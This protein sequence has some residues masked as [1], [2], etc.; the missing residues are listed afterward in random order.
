MPTNVDPKLKL[1]RKQLSAFIPDHDTIVQFERLIAYINTLVPEDNTDSAQTLLAV[2]SKANSLINE[3]AEIK[4]PLEN[5]ISVAKSGGDFTSIKDAIDSITDN[6]AENR[7]TI[8]VAPGVYTINNS[9]SPVSLKPFVG[10]IATSARQVIFQPADPAA[11]MFIGTNFAY[12]T[13]IVFSGNTTGWLVNHNVPGSMNIVDCVLRD[14]GLG[15]INDTALGTLEV[16]R[17]AINNPL[18]TTTTKA[19]CAEQGSFLFSDIVAR[20]TSIITTLIDVSGSNTQGLLNGITSISPNLTTGIKAYDGIDLSASVVNLVNPVDGIVVYGNDTDLR[21]DTCK[22]VQA[23]N[24]GFR[25]ESPGTNVVFSLFA[26]SVTGS[27]RYNFNVENPDSVLLGSGFTNIDQSFIT[28]GCELYA[29]LIDD[30]EDDEGYNILGELHVGLPERP[31]ESAIGGGDS[32]TRGM[33]VYTETELGVFVDVSEEARSASASTF[34][35]P[36]IVADNA[37]YI[38]SSLSGETDCLDH[39]GIKTK[40][41]TAAVTGAGEIVIEY[42]DGLIWAEVNGMEVDSSGGYYPHAKNYFQDTGSHHIRYDNHLAADNWTKNDPMSLGTDYYWVRF[43]I[44]TAIT[45]APIFEQF[46]LHTNRFEVNAD[47]WVEYFGSARPIGQ[48]PLSVGGDRSFAGVVQNQAIWINQ[49]LASG[50][51]ENRFTTTTGYIGRYFFAP[52]DL[53]TSSPIEM[54]IAGRPTGTGTV[55]LTIGYGH[56]TGILPG[57]RTISES[58]AV[59]AGE[60][61]IFTFHLDVSDVLARRENGSP[62]FIAISINASALTGSNFDMMALEATY[63][64]WTEGGHVS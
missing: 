6:D 49:T 60:I 59:V 43:R 58:R 29:A 32:Y 54:I 13:G 26:T 62:D 7:Y 8:L 63:S 3:I 31:V 9:S 18:G 40:V 11:D 27:A 53:D 56:V 64:K 19:L 1:T 12:I 21:F 2:E 52:Y 4:K 46:K 20:A 47:G 25:I 36:G 33:L 23:Q 55:E 24:D 45:T 57:K 34:T 10:I 16:D 22:I 39:F 51:I 38:A 28:P 61:E 14:C 15:F 37:L 50:L 48:L 30:K 35:Y 44:A 42:W 17:L 5:V 41:N